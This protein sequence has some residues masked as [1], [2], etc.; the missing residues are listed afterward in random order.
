[1]HMAFATN[2]VAILVLI[3]VPYLRP[4][5]HGEFKLF[6]DCG[7]EAASAPAEPKTAN[8]DCGHRCH[9]TR[10]KPEG[11]KNKP[12]SPEKKP[13]KQPLAPELGNGVVAQPDVSPSTAPV[14]AALLALDWWTPSAALPSRRAVAPRAPPDPVGLIV[15]R[16]Q[17]LLL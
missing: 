17:F 6:C 8:T 9:H 4:C 3:V 7:T 13:C 16:T 1:M 10:A 11:K 12:Q 5:G 14:V 15:V 2:I